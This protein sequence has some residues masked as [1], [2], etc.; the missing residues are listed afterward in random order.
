MPGHEGPTISRFE[1]MIKN[2]KCNWRARLAAG[3]VIAGL[4]LLAGR[5]DGFKPSSWLESGMIEKVGQTPE[6][7]LEFSHTIPEKLKHVPDGVTNPRFAEFQ[8]GPEGQRLS[9]YIVVETKDK[10]PTRVFVDAN[11]D[12]SF[13]KD[14]MFVWVPIVRPKPNGDEGTAYVC[15]VRMKLNEAGR[16]GVINFN[17]LPRGAF[18][19]S[20]D[21]SL[22]VCMADYGYPGELKV[23]DRTMPAALLDAD[24][25]ATFTVGGNHGKSVQMWVNTKTDGGDGREVTIPLYRGFTMEK[26]VWAITNIS[27]DGSFEVV[28]IK[29]LATRGAAKKPEADPLSPGNKAPAFTAQLMDGKPVNFPADYKGKIVLVDF[30]ATWCGPCLAEVPNVVQNFGAFHKQGLEILGISLDKSEAEKKIAKVTKDKN[31]TWP[32][33]YEGAFWDTSIAKLYEVHAIPQMLLVDGDTGEI[34]ASGKEIRGEK[35]GEAIE[36]A[37]AAKKK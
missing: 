14:E 37:L 22:L 13:S 25:S 5:A 9:H 18:S 4:S 11:A 35:L 36:S 15:N 28:A 8:T 29:D 31:M 1:F 10:V 2:Q 3:T 12:G 20:I 19:K 34:L 27:P 24:G 21:Q 7:V 23:G 26:K 16:M 30:W 6:I 17:F 33:V 32:Q